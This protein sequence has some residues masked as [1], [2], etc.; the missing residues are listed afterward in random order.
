MTTEFKVEGMMCDA[1]VSHVSNALKGVPGVSQ[2]EVDLKAERAT[3]QHEDSADVRLMA[4]AIG[5]EG[6]K[7]TALN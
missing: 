7:A 5:D 6:Y 1:C 3:V 2:V 4:T